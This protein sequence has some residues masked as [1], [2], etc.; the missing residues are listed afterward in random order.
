MLQRKGEYFDGFISK[1]DKVS[2]SYQSE[3]EII[4]LQVK[5]SLYKKSM[6]KNFP[7]GKEIFENIYNVISKNEC[8]YKQIFFDYSVA[9]DK[10]IAVLDEVGILSLIN[11]G[12]LSASELNSLVCGWLDTLDKNFFDKL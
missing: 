4:N 3:L 10:V 7:C 1:L 8:S 5:E 6:V 9:E 12:D 2:E 11:E